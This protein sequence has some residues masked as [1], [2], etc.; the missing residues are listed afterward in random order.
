MSVGAPRSRHRRARVALLAGFLVLVALATGAAL[1][2]DGPSP[3]EPLV[4]G[5]RRRRRPSRI[6]SPTTPTARTSSRAAPR[7]APATS[8]TRARPAAR[9][10]PPRASPAAARR[11]RRPRSGRASTPTC[12][13]G[14]SSSRAP[15]APDAHGGR[16]GGRGRAD[17]DPRRDRPE[18][19]RHADRRRR[20][21]AADA[22]DRAARSGAGSASSGCG[23]Q[24]RAVDE[25]FDPAKALAGTARYLT[26]RR[27]RSSAAR[28]SPSSPTTWASATSRT[29]CAPTASDE[30]SY[31]RLY[32]DS[33]PA[34]HRRRHAPAA[35]ASATTRRTT[36]GS[37]T[38]RARSCACTAT[39]R[40]ELARLEA[41]QTAKNSAEEVLHPQGSTPHFAD[42]GALRAGLRRRRRSS[43]FP[44]DPA[45]TGARARPAHG[46]ARRPARRRSRA[47]PRPAARGARAGAL[48][49]RADARVRRRARAADR[50]L[51]RARRGLPGPARAPQPRGDAQLLAA[52]DRLGV[53]HRARLPRRPPGA[54]RS[55]S[56]S[57]GSRR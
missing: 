23:A 8:S 2:G 9:P 20:E 24:R 43:P 34:T 40:S 51:D 4:P 27:A 5:D 31:A 15:D 45:R 1:R 18:P 53:R 46:R 44:D 41:L 32:F 13:R 21:R 28:T 54:R 26:I 57:T 37:S 12:S 25:R 11:S 49:R 16:H 35:C 10:P 42:P 50:H 47:L 52:H 48:H 22:P 33:T 17:A 6:R 36:C 7:P 30:P 56:C 14:S 19:A 29:C 39:T 55:S 38:R 3:G